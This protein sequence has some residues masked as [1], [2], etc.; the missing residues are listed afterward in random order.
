EDGHTMPVILLTGIDDREIDDKAASIG[1][2]DF[3]VKGE[4]SAAILDRAI[5]YAI[6]SHAAFRVLQDS[7]RGTVRAL[8]AALELRDD[9]TRAPPRL[10][11]RT[12]TRQRARARIRLPAPRHRENRRPRRN[13]AQARPARPPG[14]RTDATSRHP[15]QTDPRRDP[16]PQ[17]TR[18]R[19][20]RSTPRT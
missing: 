16:L 2:A 4:I 6:Q 15:R 12:P 8:A 9:Q 18:N 1:A 13:P 19:D 14:T 3:L 5:R 20:R 17:R 10:A 11:G 7:Y